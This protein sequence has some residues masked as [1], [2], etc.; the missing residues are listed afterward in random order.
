MEIR[1]MS[2]CAA[3]AA[4]TSAPLPFTRL[5]TP[6]GRPASCTNCAKRRALRGDS[7]LGFNTT[8][9]PAAIAGATLAVIWYNG[10]FHG[11]MRP[12]TPMGSR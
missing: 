6:A 11:V 3:M 10:Q 1:S 5:K 2:G 9:Q 4:P 12:Q 8:V 7:S